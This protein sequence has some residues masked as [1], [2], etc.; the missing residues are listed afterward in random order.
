MAVVVAD[1]HTLL[2][3]QFDRGRL[4]VRAT[5]SLDDC[6]AAAEPIRI[7]AISLVEIVYLV[8]KGRVRDDAIARF[9]SVLAAPG[10]GLLV[11]PVDAAISRTVQ[12]VARAEVPDMP[13]R[14]IAAT[15][16]H[17]GVPL[18]TRDGRIRASGIDTIW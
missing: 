17:L 16:L 15:A 5:R 8:E 6:I 14:V 3:Y 9:D 4:S 10:G 11:V 7:S 18:V 12:R 2:W 13:D 1:T